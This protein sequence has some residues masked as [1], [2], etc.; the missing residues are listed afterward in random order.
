MSD[1]HLR[2]VADSHIW[3]LHAA[4]SSLPGFDVDLQ[5]VNGE[6][7]TRKMLQEADVL[8]TRSSTRV[9]ARLLKGTN[10]RFAATATIGDDHYDKR[11][12]QANG[13]SWAGAGGSSTGSVVEYM[14][15]LLLELHVR[16]LISIPDATLGIVGVGRIGSALAGV[17]E[18]LGMQ[19]FC[20]DPPRERAER[21]VAFSSMQRLLDEA[22][23][24]TLHTPL[25][26][27]GGDRT[28]HL[29]DSDW[30]SRFQGSV[31][32]N[33]ARGGCVDNEALLSWLDGDA[34]RL[35][36][37]DCWE[38]EP[39]I[40]KP[41]LAHPQLVIATPHIAGHS[42]DGKAANTRYIYDALCSFL[43]IK[44]VWSMQDTLPA[45]ERA[46]YVVAGDE[47]WPDL[48]KLATM[49][50]P[51]MRDDQVM[52]SWLELPD[53]RLAGSFSAFRRNY[54]V[55]RAWESGQVTVV[56]ASKLF[57]QY[58]HAIGIDVF[59]TGR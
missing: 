59:N 13:I 22:D 31:V 39:D 10:V 54:P 45:V 43:G 21:G 11:W 57:T 44:P 37:L 6:A 12:L 56:N 25:L 18:N 48:H 14:I 58:A 7:I 29:I 32:I 9:D 1:R 40:L 19:I 30:L 46:A 36:V 52:K 20:N 15:T 4:F 27:H 49:L 16:G 23:I 3:G 26:H 42:L 2:I 51:I 47:L 38:N 28:F 53:E 55:R 35:A 17:C 8:L 50:Y 41:L 24:V 5:A 34:E 33:A